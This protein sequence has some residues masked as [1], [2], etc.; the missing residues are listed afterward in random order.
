V[1]NFLNPGM[2]WALIGLPIL[3]LLVALSYLRRRAMFGAYSHKSLA[4]KVTRPLPGN[5]Y[6][7][8]GAL[9]C[10]G[11]G[12]LIVAC[13][14]PV[15]EAQQ[16]EF[17][18][19]NVDAIAIVDV[20]R[21]MAALEYKD[22]LPQVNKTEHGT[23]L[24]M[25]RQLITTKLLPAMRGNQLGVVSYAGEANPQAPLSDDLKPLSWVLQRALTISSATG[26]GS[27]MVKAVE[28]AFRLFDADSPADHQRLI[29]LFSD[30]GNDD[31]DEA[32]ARVAQ[33]CVK[34]GIKV[35][36]VGL[37][38]ITPSPIPVAELAQDDEV[39]RALMQNGKVYYENN[40][41]V[42]KT[43]LNETPLI[44]LANKTAGRYVRL[45]NANDLE[46]VSMS[47]A[48]T[49][50]KSKGNR[51]LFGYPLMVAVACGFL[52]LLVTRQLRGRQK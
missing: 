29:V 4:P 48:R 52:G 51:E 24:D 40:G 35:T 34:R 42:E 41:E 18:R 3:A 21:S 11:A 39:A 32:L 2:L 36:V 46:I 49:I 50:S 19:G 6:L 8:K 33:E 38:S 15:A 17:P 44:Q 13:A 45:N 23:R 47:K 25:A 30:G 28:M 22:K 5:R 26:E 12:A 20:S 16:A 37:G 9:L 43:A 14:R 27:A 10:L 31:G 1:P 7:V